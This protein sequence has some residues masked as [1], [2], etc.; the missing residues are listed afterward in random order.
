[1]LKSGVIEV[2]REVI[3]AEK[4]EAADKEDVDVTLVLTTCIIP[5]PPPV[6]TPADA[7]ILLTFNVLIT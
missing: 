5:P 4:S 6:G 1:M 2:L 7:I 3:T